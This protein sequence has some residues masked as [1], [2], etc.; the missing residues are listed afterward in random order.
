M[1]Y[2][3]GARV[4]EWTYEREGTRVKGEEREGKVRGE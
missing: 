3:G 2:G 1:G 4:V